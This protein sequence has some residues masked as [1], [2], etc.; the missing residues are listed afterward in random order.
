MDTWR[1]MGHMSNLGKLDKRGYKKKIIFFWGGGGG[2]GGGRPYSGL[3]VRV[4]EGEK[5]NKKFKIK[6]S[7]FDPRSSASRNLSSQK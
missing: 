3:V 4:R 7:F 5:K 1:D 2:G 6:V